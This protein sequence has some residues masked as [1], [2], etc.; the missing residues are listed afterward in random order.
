[1]STTQVL[2]SFSSKEKVC[3]GRGIQSR[4][5]ALVEFLANDATGGQWSVPRS[6]FC[7]LLVHLMTRGV[8]PIDGWLPTHT[9]NIDFIIVPG[10]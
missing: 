1:M 8:G 6:P 3:F 5:R 4:D 2:V 10:S 7:F 9:V